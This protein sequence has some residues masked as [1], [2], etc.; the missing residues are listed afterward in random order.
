MLVTSVTKKYLF[1]KTQQKMLFLC[2]NVVESK[3]EVTLCKNTSG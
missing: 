2:Y 1:Q 3:K